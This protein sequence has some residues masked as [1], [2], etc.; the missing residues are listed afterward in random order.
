M[1]HAEC[2]VGTAPP[3]LVQFHGRTTFPTR[4][5]STPL[6]SLDRTSPLLRRASVCTLPCGLFAQASCAIPS[7]RTQLPNLFSTS[8]R[9][10]E[11]SNATTN[12]SCTLPPGPSGL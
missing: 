8:Y 4:Q 6:V 9:S 3:C 1:H 2:S 12:H 7:L 5:P 10:E 11:C